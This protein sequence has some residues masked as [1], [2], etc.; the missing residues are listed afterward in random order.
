MEDGEIK[1]RASNCLMR[2]LSV[3]DYVKIRNC[4]CAES[5]SVFEELFMKVEPMIKAAPFC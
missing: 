1:F 2:D 3:H 4:L 5:S